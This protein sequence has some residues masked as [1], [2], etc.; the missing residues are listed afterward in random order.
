[1]N[2]P[3][4]VFCDGH[5]EFSTQSAGPKSGKNY[6]KRSELHENAIRAPIGLIPSLSLRDL[7]AKRSEK[8]FV[9]KK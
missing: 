2:E 1:M 4:V 8:G 5:F 7:Q 3:C 6:G 9:D